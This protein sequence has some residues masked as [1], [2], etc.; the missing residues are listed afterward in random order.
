MR[1]GEARRGWMSGGRGMVEV[2]MREGGGRS[3]EEVLDWGFDAD[4]PAD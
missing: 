1:G 4:T 3:F 2:R